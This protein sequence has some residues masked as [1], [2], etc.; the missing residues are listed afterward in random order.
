MSDTEISIVPNSTNRMIVCN[1][2]VVHAHSANGYR[3]L[4]RKAAR[5]GAGIG[6]VDGRLHRHID[7]TMDVMSGNGVLRLHAKCRSNCVCKRTRLLP[8][9]GGSRQ[10]AWWNAPVGVASGR[11]SAGGGYLC[12]RAVA[13]RLSARLRLLPFGGGSRQ[14]A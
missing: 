6:D 4:A 11:C 5:R 2:Y 1:K 7:G 14:P 13:G 10:P 3:D 9:E 12:K 8:F